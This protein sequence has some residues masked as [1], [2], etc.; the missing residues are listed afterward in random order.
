MSFVLYQMINI[1][2][3]K[4]SNNNNSNKYFNKNLDFF[5]KHGYL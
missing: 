4:M 3:K 1:N 2:K 5:R